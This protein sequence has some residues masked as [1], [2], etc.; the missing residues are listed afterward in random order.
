MSK[1]NPNIIKLQAQKNR[2]TIWSV[3]DSNREG[4]ILN[5]DRQIREIVRNVLRSNKVKVSEIIIKR[6]GSRIILI[7]QI[8]RQRKSKLGKRSI[9][10]SKSKKRDRRKVLLE[11]I[12]NRLKRN[13]E[14]ESY[15]WNKNIG[16]RRIKLEKVMEI[17]VE[18]LSYIYRKEVYI[19]VINVYGTYLNAELLV[20]WISRKMNK[21]KR[22][23]KKLLG[24]ILKRYKKITEEADIVEKIVEE[25]YNRKKVFMHYISW[26]WLKELGQD[27]KWNQ[28]GVLKGNGER[29]IPGGYPLGKCKSINKIGERCIEM[30]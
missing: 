21:G 18:R 15:N 20:D 16:L 3:R 26:K 6:G 24:R 30:K 19:K 13:K 28:L 2:T 10:E 1:I 9:I 4:V 7:F 11:R 23:H 12:K 8:R 25:N 27:S 29:K 22:N 5:E 17:L 14:I